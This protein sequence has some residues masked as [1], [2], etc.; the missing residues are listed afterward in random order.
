M[1]AD[2]VVQ[3]FIEKHADSVARLLESV[4]PDEMGDFLTTLSTEQ[5]A[6]IVR[7]LGRRSACH[8]LEALETE[9]AVE[10]IKA[11]PIQ[12][13]AALVRDMPAPGKKA[14]LASDG[15]PYRIK[16]ILRFPKGSV[17]A[18]MDSNP[19]TLNEGLT[20]KQARAFLKKYREHISDTLFVTGIE[21]QFVGVVPLKDL[22]FADHTA[23]VSQVCKPPIHRLSPREALV[24]VGSHPV[25]RQV[26]ALPVVDRGG[27]LAG[28][29]HR[30][31]VQNTLNTAPASPALTGDV[32]DG[33]FSLGEL[34][35]TTC[36][37]MLSGYSTS[38][39]PERS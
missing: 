8:Y 36:A 11:L 34:F 23:D 28:V 19:V 38:A 9:Q 31:M 3:R 22:L 21:Q 5:A 2:P 26:S 27:R 25:W 14:L 32:A 37:D 30:D 1:A 20:V 4:D 12:Y 13:A 17:G 10:F 7:H 29:L 15:V 24:S 18:E 33:M 35:W 16:T 39:Q 6:S